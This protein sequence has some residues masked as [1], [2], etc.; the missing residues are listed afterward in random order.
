MALLDVLDRHG[1]EYDRPETEARLNLL[2][3]G[4]RR[5]PNFEKELA[6]FKQKKGGAMDLNSLKDKI[7]IPVQ[8]TGA[9]DF[10]GPELRWFIETI[11]SDRIDQ[12]LKQGRIVFRILFTVLFFISYN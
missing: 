5:D 8:K 7:S 1:V 9:Q 2:V 4:L 10:L 6:E 12:A 11:E 3:K